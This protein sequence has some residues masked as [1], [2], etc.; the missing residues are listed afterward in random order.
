MPPAKT[1]EAL[2]VGTLDQI[3]LAA[4]LGEATVPVPQWNMSV[5]VRGLSRGE[6]NESAEMDDRQIGYL[7][8]G[9][10]DPPVTMEEAAEL[11]GKKS[12]LAVQVIL[13]EIINQSG[14]GAGFRQGEAD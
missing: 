11:V 9:M 1:K 7:H 2:P 6:V 13:E 12:Y 10:V 4:D 3:R 14:L 5:R 8:Y